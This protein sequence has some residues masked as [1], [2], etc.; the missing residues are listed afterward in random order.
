[1]M[2]QAPKVLFWGLGAMGGGMAAMALD[3]ESLDVVAAIEIPER[4]G[5]DLGEVLGRVKVG[6][7]VTD[8]PD[9]AFARAPDVALI[10]TS[11]FA[12][13]VF[14]RIKFALEKGANVITI[15]EEMAF[16]WASQPDRPPRWIL[17]QRKRA[18]LCSVRINP[19]LS[20]TLWSF[21]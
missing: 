2:S 20:S 5:K 21:P 7:T 3:R 16:P 12:K 19:G 4:A 14:P 10:C 17:S 15:A 8:D 13:D 9:T 1:M 18:R 6:V 11:S